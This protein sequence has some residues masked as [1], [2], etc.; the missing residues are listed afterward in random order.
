MKKSLLFLT[1]GLMAGGLANA[2]DITGVIHFKGAA[3]AERE[4][5][6]I[7]DDPIPLDDP[8]DAS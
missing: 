2:A 1:L 6:P 8:E 4:L 5:T 7:K 3:P